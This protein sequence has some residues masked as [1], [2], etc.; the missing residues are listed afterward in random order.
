MSE[1][2]VIAAFPRRA[3]TV[4]TGWRARLA[5]LGSALMVAAT[6]GGAVFV[7]AGEALRIEQ[8]RRIWDRGRPAPVKDVRGRCRTNILM[9]SQCSLTVTYEPAAG[10][11]AQAEVS[12]LVFGGLDSPLPE[13]A[14]RIDPTEPD[15]I[16]LNTVVEAAPQ[17]WIAVAEVA[18]GLLFLSAVIG[19][20]VW[21]GLREWRLRRILARDP[22]PVAARVL[23]S[24]TVSTP[25]YAHEITFEYDGPNG[26]RT[27]RQRLAVRQA[28]QGTPPTEWRYREP[29]PLD[30][31]GT[32]LL[33]L[34]G[35]QGAL[36]VEDD[37][38]PLVLTQAEK[39]AILAARG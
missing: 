36:L 10:R 11:S 39:A 13:P 25:G 26:P 9:A 31:D 8:D 34:A 19:F 24:R 2:K 30:P 14:V 28:Q 33:A 35:P 18:G 1:S 6:L 29:I 22:R 4:R 7:G 16:A 20:G 37:F 21:M 32:R 3:I 12:A 27:A 38:H 23:R 5:L 15:R 17:R